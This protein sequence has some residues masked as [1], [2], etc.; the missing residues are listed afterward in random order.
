MSRSKRKPR[1]LLGQLHLLVGRGPE[2]E[3]AKS[4]EASVP[5]MRLHGREIFH[6]ERLQHFF[7]T[8]FGLSSSVSVQQATA[9]HSYDDS[10]IIPAL[11]DAFVTRAHVARSPTSC[12][13]HPLWGRHFSLRYAARRSLFMFLPTCPNVTDVPPS[14]SLSQMYLTFHMLQEPFLSI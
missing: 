8:H 13:R 11:P 14:F 3:G 6:L 12:P 1:L 10:R 5:P 4:A 2:D 9:C 7:L